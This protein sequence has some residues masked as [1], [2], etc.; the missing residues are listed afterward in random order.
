MREIIVIKPKNWKC[1]KC[2]SKEGYC[3]DCKECL[4]CSELI[5]DEN[6]TLKSGSVIK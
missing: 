2:G 5:G 4:I 6:C 3:K 1:K